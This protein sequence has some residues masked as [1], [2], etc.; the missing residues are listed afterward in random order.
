MLSGLRRLAC[1]GSDSICWPRSGS[2]SGTLGTLRPGARA[3]LVALRDDPLRDILATER[4][5]LVMKDGV[6]VRRRERGRR[7]VGTDRP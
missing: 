1:A 2:G 3:D 4:V 5:A 7:E 6:I